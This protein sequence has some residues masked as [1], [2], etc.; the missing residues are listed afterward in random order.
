MLSSQTKYELW[1]LYSFKYEHSFSVGTGCPHQ[2]FCHG[3]AGAECDYRES[4]L[5]AAML[6]G[7]QFLKLAA[8]KAV[9]I[10]NE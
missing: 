9:N 2:L 7:K 4:E 8:R 6:R 3:Q 10:I 5:V 1:V